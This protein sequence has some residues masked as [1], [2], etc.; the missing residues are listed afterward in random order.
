MVYSREQRIKLVKL[1]YKNK[2]CAIVIA[3][4]F[5]K[6]HPEQEVSPQHVNT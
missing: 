3:R 6:E 2:T 5:N 1:Y 4:L